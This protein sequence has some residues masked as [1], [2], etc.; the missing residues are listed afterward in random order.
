M[1]T[2][3]SRTTTQQASLRTENLSLCYGQKFAFRNI[4]LQIPP[5]HI[6]AIVGPSGS[7][8]SSFLNCLNRLTDLIPNCHVTGK[9]YLSGQNILQAEM[10]TTTLR[11]RVGMLFQ[12]PNPFPFSI[13]KNLAFPLR[14]HGIKD[15]QQ[16]EQIITTSLQ[17]VGLWQEVKDRLKMSALRLSGGQ[18][19]RLCLAR[20][21]ALKPEIILMDEPCSALDPLSSGHIEDLIQQLG[22]HYT[23]VI[24]THNLAQAKRIAHQTAL[25]WTQE[26]CGQLIEVATTSAFFNNPVDP[27]TQ[28]YVEGL[29]G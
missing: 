5:Q 17:S 14:E 1:T 28:A 16:I 13:Y 29:R 21:I 7:G 26:N 20:T 4:S 3:Q 25:F 22:N 10:N 2:L 23:V 27:L 12:Q 8:K 19:Q 6:T 18:Q 24:I 11:R 15:R 9:I